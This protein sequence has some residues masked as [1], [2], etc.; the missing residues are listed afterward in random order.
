MRGTGLSTTKGYRQLGDALESKI[1]SSDASTVRRR[2]EGR[3][4]GIMILLDLKLQQESGLDY[5]RR[6]RR[7]ANVAVGEVNSLRS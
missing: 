7:D 1:M 6:S 4:G 2:C 3:G 5:S